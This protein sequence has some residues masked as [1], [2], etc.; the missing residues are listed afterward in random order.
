MRTL[1]FDISKIK[2]IIIFNVSI[3]HSVVLTVWNRMYQRND[4]IIFENSSKRLI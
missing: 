4:Q 2:K 3:F 1:I